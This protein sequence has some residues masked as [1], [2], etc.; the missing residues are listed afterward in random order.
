MSNQKIYLGTKK[1]YYQAQELLDT[2]L[3]KFDSLPSRGTQDL[4]SELNALVQKAVLLAAYL[5]HR[6]NTGCGD[7]GHAASAKKANRALKL[8]RKA[9][10]FTYPDEG[11]KVS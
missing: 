4:A 3:S 8:V 2:P 7:Q 1:A 11:A 6:Y 9:L 10:G 5:D